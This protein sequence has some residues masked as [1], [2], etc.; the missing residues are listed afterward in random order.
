MA[1]Y[2]GNYDIK[3]GRDFRYQNHYTPNFFYRP[4]TSVDFAKTTFWMKNTFS[5][6]SPYYT[7]ASEEVLQS[8]E[9]V[10]TYNCQRK[11]QFIS[12]GKFGDTFNRGVTAHWKF[13]STWDDL[14][15]LY[16]SSY[17][18]T[19][20]DEPHCVTCHY[21]K[22]Y[23]TRPAEP[24][25]WDTPSSHAYND[26]NHFGAVRCKDK[27]FDVGELNAYGYF[28]D[29]YQGIPA[30]TREKIY[31]HHPR[32][33]NYF[34]GNQ[35]MI[36][37]T[38]S[39]TEGHYY[40]DDDYAGMPYHSRMPRTSDHMKEMRFGS[41]QIFAG[42]HR[43]LI[44]CLDARNEWTFD[45]DTFVWKGLIYYFT[46][47]MQPDME[48]SSFQPLTGED[49]YPLSDGTE[50]R[51]AGRLLYY[52][53]G[54]GEPALWNED[55]ISSVEHQ[56]RND[57][58]MI[59]FAMN[60]D[61][62]Q[63]YGSKTGFLLLDNRQHQGDAFTDYRGFIQLGDGRVY[64]SNGDGGIF[65]DTDNKTW[66]F[67]ESELGLEPELVPTWF[68][69]WIWM[70]DSYGELT[71]AIVCHFHP[72]FGNTG[73]SF[74]LAGSPR[75]G[76]E[77]QKAS[78]YGCN[79]LCMVSKGQGDDDGIALYTRD[80]DYIR[81]LSRAD[82]GYYQ[83]HGAGTTPSWGSNDDWFGVFQTVYENGG[84]GNMKWYNNQGTGS[85]GQI[86]NDHIVIKN[87][88]IFV[89]DSGWRFDLEDAGYDGYYEG[90]LI[91]DT[92]HNLEVHGRLYIYNLEGVLLVAI[93]PGDL[94][95]NTGHGG[96]NYGALNPSLWHWDKFMTDGHD[97]FLIDSNTHILFSTITNLRVEDTLGAY[98]EPIID[99]FRY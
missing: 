36:T 31:F 1:V 72:L 37:P 55:F 81:T 42:D 64:F 91:G 17:Q 14:T 66:E 7:T 23:Y 85:Q 11:D 92:S 48:L 51:G 94:W 52:S 32:P 58:I 46:K 38:T 2:L 35:R 19:L 15:W 71:N 90:Y 57:K 86:H 95:W 13:K 26:D 62:Y 49:T 9:N 61:T 68:R 97:I 93:S 96:M 84:N 33:G 6:P 39:Q 34:S 44:D 65:R 12:I 50:A 59:H 73:G 87:N 79:R 60:S 40:G 74:Y 41:H 80:G 67:S 29:L 10:L 45:G 5:Y 77:M 4:S 89:F 47:D 54:T 22:T 82:D 78:A 63:S 75:E 98:F 21:G 70:S 8:Y 3:N 53:D 76:Y 99:N 16:G 28:A 20:T 88:L 18:F 43:I 24:E 69:S 56:M 27:H 25:Q 83:F 30:S